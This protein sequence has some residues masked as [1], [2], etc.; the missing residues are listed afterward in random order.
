MGLLKSADLEAVCRFCSEVEVCKF[1]RDIFDALFG[2]LGSQQ[3]SGGEVD[4][5]VFQ[6]LVTILGIVADRRFTNFKPV[7]DVY[8][9][10]HFH[11]SRASSHIISSLQ[12]LLR[13]STSPEAA[14][15][16]RSSIKV[17]HHLFKFVVRSREIQRAKDVGMGVT[18]EHLETTFKRELSTLL[19]AVNT[20][21]RSTSPSSIIGTQTLAVQHFASILPDL[22][23]CFSQQELAD[24]AISFCDAVTPKG[25]II[26]WKLVL[27]NQL[28]NSVVFASPTG[29]AALVPNVVRWIKPSLGKFDEH[30]LSPKDTQATRDNARVSWIEGIRLAAGVVA[31]MLDMLQEALMDPAIQSSRSLLGQEQDSI[32]YILGILPRLLESYREVEN[33]VN[34]DSVERQRSQASVVTPIPV[35]FPSSYPFS[36]LSHPPE[37]ARLERERARTGKEATPEET[38]SEWPTLRAGMGEIACVFIAL[39]HL[40]PRKILVNWLDSTFEVEG[41]DNFARL[42]TQVFRVGKSI[43]ENDAYPSDWLNIN[44]LA[45]RVIVKVIDPIA[46]VLERE[47]IPAQQASYTF[48]TSLWRD[49]FSMLLR[50]LSS[51]QLLIEEFSPQKR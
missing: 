8:I 26:V 37:H 29:R 23:K 15:T 12:K 41:K 5:L 50:L 31:C 32:E 28:V 1:L 22:A 6:A 4:E 17:W 45:H 33:L 40:A 24:I 11:S 39:L 30:L 25:K 19:A 7:L 20:M 14:T 51:P 34:L 47:F 46:D 18:S 3:N 43:L 42:L 21:M 2:I 48:N 13:T 35:V 10:R 16:L 36:L 27:E 9:D 38:K 44:I 49:F